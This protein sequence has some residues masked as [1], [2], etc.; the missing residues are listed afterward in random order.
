MAQFLTAINTSLSFAQSAGDKLPA[1][2]TRHDAPAQPQDP[3][4]PK[5]TPEKATNRLQ[6]LD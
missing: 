6:R 2:F 1:P 3:V 5:W 4:K